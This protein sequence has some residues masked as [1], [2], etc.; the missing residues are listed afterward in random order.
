MI[1]GPK[2]LPGLGRQ[3]GAGMREFKDSITR[4]A[5]DEDEDEDEDDDAAGA[6]RRAARRPPRSATGRRAPRSPPRTG[7]PPRS[8]S[9]G[10]SPMATA[11]R[12]IRHEDRLSLVEHLDELRTRLIICDRRLRR[13]LRRLPVAERRDPRHH[14]PPARGD[15]VQA[16]QGLQGP[17]RAHRGLPGPAAQDRDRVGGDLRRPRAR[18]AAMPRAR[19]R[20][21]AAGHREPRA[22]ARRPAARRRGGR[23]RSASASR[24][25]RR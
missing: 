18:R 21:P 14:Q 11:L 22:R 20:L 17:V 5:D 24:S 2:R 8:A 4:K 10:R 23:S 25:P 19:A 1:F 13:L 6:R 12:P 15:G 16:E 9:R 7:S 3:L